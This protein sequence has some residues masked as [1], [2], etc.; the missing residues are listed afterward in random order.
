MH[1]NP[2]SIHFD[3]QRVGMQLK[4]KC[5]ERMWNITRVWDRNEMKRAMEKDFFFC[6]HVNEFFFWIQYVRSFGCV[7]QIIQEEETKFIF[8]KNQN[9]V[10]ETKT[11]RHTHNTHCTL[12]MHSAHIS[13]YSHTSP[14]PQA[15][16]KETVRAKNE[17]IFQTA[18]SLT[19]YSFI[20]SVIV[21][22]DIMLNNV[23]I[24][25]DMQFKRI[26]A[27][28]N[29]K[30]LWLLIKPKCE[31]TTIYRAVDDNTILLPMKKM[32]QKTK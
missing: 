1:P 27:M 31:H 24:Y 8:Q 6:W 11:Y 12:H 10:W 28:N 13:L 16:E 19:R 9:W 14:L 32:K 18:N 5:E 30:C 3:H 26:N 7:E 17:G 25:F 22:F 4:E 2:E 21:S 23:H 15:K 29:F 20:H